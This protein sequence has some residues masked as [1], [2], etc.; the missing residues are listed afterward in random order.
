MRPLP[1]S[2]VE[3]ITLAG[4]PAARS[5]SRLGAALAAGLLVATGLLGESRA[6]ARAAEDAFGRDVELAPFVVRGE[7][8]AVSIHARSARD[9]S[10]AESFAEDVVK[11]IYEAVTEGTGKGLVIV[12]AKGE[13]HPIV[14]F[15]TFQRLAEAG[16]L[17]PEVAAHAAELRSFL[18][19]WTKAM[20]ASKDR[21]PPIEPAA[22]AEAEPASGRR[23]ARHVQVDLD[24]EEIANAFPLPLEGVGARLYQLGWAERFDETKLDARLRALRPGD[25]EHDGFARFDWV[26]YLP[27]RGVLDRAMKEVIN[28]ALRQAEL[29]F[30]TRM[31]ARTILAVMKP[32]LRRAIEGVRKGMLFMT[33]V[34][35]QTD[36]ADDQVSALASAYVATMMP[37]SEKKGEGSEHERAVAAVREAM[38]GWEGVRAVA[39]EGSEAGLVS[40]TTPHASGAEAT[41]AEP[42]SGG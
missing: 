36:W 42:N 9:R 4:Y 40:D 20:E 25:L 6:T 11:V 31:A 37:G 2:S 12:G 29:G 16:E 35:E 28:E 17:Q 10:Y 33:I 3:R 30:F 5:W 18:D 21:T 15:R 32:Q 23:E 38:S 8:L 26:F 39:G 7:Q 19:R 13:P 34:H 41:V 1:A 27:P 14:V 22:E 24:F